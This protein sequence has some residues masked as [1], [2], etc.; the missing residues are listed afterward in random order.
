MRTRSA[1]RAIAKGPPVSVA[2]LY[3]LYLLNETR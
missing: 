3:L 1:V 2:D